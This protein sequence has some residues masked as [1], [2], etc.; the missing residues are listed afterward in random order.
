MVS[1]L[2]SCKKT[3]YNLR[4]NPE[5]NNG[6]GLCG[7]NKR[8]QKNSSNSIILFYGCQRVVVQILGSSLENGLALIE[9][10]MCCQIIQYCYWHLLTLN[11]I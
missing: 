10:N 8:I 5:R 1:K 2:E 6:I 4:W 11:Q 9:Y 3:D 7:V